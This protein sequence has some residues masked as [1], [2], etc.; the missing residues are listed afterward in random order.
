MRPISRPAKRDLEAL[1]GSSQHVLGRHLEV[2][3]QHLAGLVAAMAELALLA[4][5]AVAR[6]A[7]PDQ[8]GGDAAL[9]ESGVGDRE[10][11][12][13]AGGTPRGHE[14]LRAVE[15]VAVAAPHSPGGEVGRVRTCLR[16]GQEHAG[17]L[18]ATRHGREKSPL[19]IRR[20][21]GE[22]LEG[23]RVGRRHE[24]A[25]AGVSVGKLLHRQHVGDH[26]RAGATPLAGDCHAE[27]SE[28]SRLAHRGSIDGGSPVPLG[29]KGSDLPAHE[30]AG[31]VPDG[32][33]FARELRHARFPAAARLRRPPTTLQPAGGEARSPIPLMARL[34]LGLNHGSAQIALAPNGPIDNT[35]TCRCR[36]PM[37]GRIPLVFFRTSAGNGRYANG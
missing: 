27:Q 37:T 18:L 20:A 3:E 29:G 31:H 12:G 24:I 9:A 32:K 1:A 13:A 30:R 14:R 34:P 26:I 15:D 5:D 8:E 25:E 21:R 33:L 4:Q 16:L 35:C 23:E 6:S 2:L 7:G 36:A 11:D 17:D 19:L 22:H 28:L 10:H